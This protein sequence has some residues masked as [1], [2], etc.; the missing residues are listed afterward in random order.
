MMWTRFWDIH[1]GGG[2]K[3]KWAMIYIEAPEKEACIIFQNRFGRNPFRITCTCCGEDY[4]VQEYE[5]LEQ[6][7]GYHRGCHYDDELHKYVEMK[8]KSKYAHKDYQ[9]VEEYKKQEDVLV[10]YEKDI[11]IEE[12]VGEL[13]EEGYVWRD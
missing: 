13:H 4:S 12:K 2:Q 10:I 11:K 1:S 5:T 9:T 3:L 7:T 8:D 6:V